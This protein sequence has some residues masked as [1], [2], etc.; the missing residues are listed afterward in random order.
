VTEFSSNLSTA[1]AAMTEFASS[2]RAFNLR[3][4]RKANATATNSTRA[5]PL[6]IS[7]R[8]F[9]KDLRLFSVADFFPLRFLA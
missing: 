6:K 9:K 7:Q 8:I 3:G 5:T 4:L 1:P 2:P